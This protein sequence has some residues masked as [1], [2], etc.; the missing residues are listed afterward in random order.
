MS[1]WPNDYMEMVVN[2]VNKYNGTRKIIKAGLIERYTV[3]YSSPEKLHP[4]PND[5]FSQPDIGP[6]LEIVSKY[7]V[8]ARRCINYDMPVFE[9]PMI[10]QKMEPDGYMLLNGHHRWFAAIRAQVKKVH[11]KIIN[12]VSEA[13]VHRMINDTNNTR[14]VSFDFDEVLLSADENNQSPIINSLF[15]RKIKERLRIGA[16]EVIR[17]FRAS[18]FDVC[19]YTA[20]YLTEEEIRDFFSMYDLEVNIIVNGINEKRKNV[21]GGRKHLKELLRDRYKQIVHVDNESVICTNHTYMDYDIYDISDYA[22]V[23]STGIENIINTVLS[24]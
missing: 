5:E 4:N 20:G 10:V 15:S 22:S 23:W 8:E 7:G 2:D 17:A 16:P 11:I 21:E 3:R 19:V 9:E 24:Q 13:D 12:L 6:N 1:V 14:L 18:D